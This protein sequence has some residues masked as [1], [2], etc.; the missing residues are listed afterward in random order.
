MDVSVARRLKA[1]ED[2]NAKL[3]RMLADSMR[4]RA[5]PTLS[6]PKLPKT[7]RTLLTTSGTMAASAEL[8]S[9]PASAYLHMLIL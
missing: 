8:S 1:L 7:R 6:I 3:K 2:E 5:I 9:A 4:V